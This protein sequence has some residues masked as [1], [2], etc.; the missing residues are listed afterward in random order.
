MKI[1]LVSHCKA[2]R[3]DQIKE[4]IFVR[5]KMPAKVDK[6]TSDDNKHDGDVTSIVCYGNNLYSAG[7]DGKIKVRAELRDFE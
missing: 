6:V 1:C 7:S 3:K 4:E 2:T 5:N